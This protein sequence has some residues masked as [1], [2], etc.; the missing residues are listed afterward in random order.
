MFVR[1]LCIS[2]CLKVMEVNSSAVRSGKQV[3][4]LLQEATQSHQ[5]SQKNSDTAGNNIKT[6]NAMRSFF[7]PLAAQP[8]VTKP[9]SPSPAGA[10]VSGFAGPSLI[11]FE[12]VSLFLLLC[13]RLGIG[14][15]G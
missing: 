11:L 5:M 10:G 4:S 15:C 3:M 1:F 7:K 9:A 13:C 6:A 2:Y 12:E 14:V 8:K